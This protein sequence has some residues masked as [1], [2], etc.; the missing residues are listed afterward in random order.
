ML[1][2]LLERHRIVGKMG[3]IVEEVL[4]GDKRK[5]G[6]A[7]DYQKP[8][9]TLLDLLVTFLD[10]KAMEMQDCLDYPSN[11]SHHFSATV[12]N[13]PS[14]EPHFIEFVYF[15]PMHRAFEPLDLIVRRIGRCIQSGYTEKIGTALVEPTNAHR[16][17]C[18]LS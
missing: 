17:L 7:L 5:E 10:D 12:R 14:N 3:N 6:K 9:E 11:N 8:L 15:S 2:V 16:R 4:I 1:F 18:G 13:D